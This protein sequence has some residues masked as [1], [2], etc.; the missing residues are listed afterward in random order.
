MCEEQKGIKEAT[1][2]VAG[3]DVKVAVASGLG[4]A[5][6]ASEQ[7]EVRR[8]QTTTLSRSWAARAAAS[9]AAASLRQ[10]G[11]CAE[12]Y[13]CAGDP[14]RACC[15]DNDEAKPIRKSHENP[16]IKKL[17]EEYLGEPG[18]HKA[19][20]YLHTTYVKRSING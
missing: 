11:R 16:A 4:N 1:Y 20:E 5:R 7:S 10:S 3:M 8:S 6:D 18:S 14:R 9:T 2:N 15:T 12:L 17:Y 13:G 19:H